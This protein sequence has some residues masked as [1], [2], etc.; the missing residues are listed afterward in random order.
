MSIFV[1]VGVLCNSIR[2]TPRITLKFLPFLTRMSRYM[3]LLMHKI[4]VKFQLSMHLCA[5]TIH[6]D[7]EHDFVAVCTK[8]SKNLFYNQ[9]GS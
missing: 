5:Y 3:H 9:S 2:R 1:D 4:I 8:L 7:L 6:F